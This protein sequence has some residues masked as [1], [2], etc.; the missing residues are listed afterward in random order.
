MSSYG[1]MSLSHSGSLSSHNSQQNFSGTHTSSNSHATGQ[2]STSR[3]QANLGQFDQMFPMM[4]ISELLGTDGD[5][6]GNGEMEL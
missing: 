3:R 6:I 1:Q 2:S 5:D 4:A